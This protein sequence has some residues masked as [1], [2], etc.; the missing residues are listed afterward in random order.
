MFFP[1]PIKIL[2]EVNVLERKTEIMYVT[3]SENPIYI[4][5]KSDLSASF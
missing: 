1:F 3:G 2:I 5:F 4:E